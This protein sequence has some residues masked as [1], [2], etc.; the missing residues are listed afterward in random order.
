L[1]GALGADE[2]VDVGGGDDDPGPTVEEEVVDVDVDFDFD[3]GGEGAVV[4]VAVA[5]SFPDD[6][7][8]ELLGF[9]RIS[10]TARFCCAETCGAV[11]HAATVQARAGTRS[12][13]SHLLP[14]RRRVCLS[15]PLPAPTG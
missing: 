1:G 13:T 6:R 10:A 2:A 15:F 7:A 8:V 11:E 14:V 4:V 12:N 9:C 3:G 5:F